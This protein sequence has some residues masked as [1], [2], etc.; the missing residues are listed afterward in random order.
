MFKI[1]SILIILSLIILLVLRAVFQA[2]GSP[3]S[4]YVARLMWAIIVP[5]LVIF[6]LVLVIQVFSW[7]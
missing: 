7:I 2:E 1:L 4:R 3:G 5:F 6:G